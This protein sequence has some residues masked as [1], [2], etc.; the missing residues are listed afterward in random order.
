MEDTIMYEKETE[1]KLGIGGKLKE[2]A[3][4]KV[5]IAIGSAG[6]G[7]LAYAGGRVLL[8]Y[9]REK[10]ALSEDITEETLEVEGEPF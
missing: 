2:L 8:A 5:V 3:N 7:A 10:F 6:I 1:K 4:N 9:L